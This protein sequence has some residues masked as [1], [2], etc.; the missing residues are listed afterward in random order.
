MQCGRIFPWTLSLEE[1]QAIEAEE[2]EAEQRRWHR[3]RNLQQE[4][5]RE[6]ARENALLAKQRGKCTRLPALRNN[7]HSGGDQTERKWQ[8]SPLASPPPSPPT[9]PPQRQA[10]KHGARSHR[11]KAAVTNVKQTPP[12]ECIR[13]FGPALSDV[14]IPPSADLQARKITLPGGGS[15]IGYFSGRISVW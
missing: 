6:H 9:T 5:R 11:G 12:H 2:N 10:A 3:W 1:R 8:P 4:V 13:S 7:S 14:W 15:Y